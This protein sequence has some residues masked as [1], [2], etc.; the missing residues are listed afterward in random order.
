MQL[1]K[2]LLDSL[3]SVKG[4][5]K[6]AFEK[7]HSSGE[8]VTSIRINPIKWLMVNGEFDPPTDTK[9]EALSGS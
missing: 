1:P 5:N 7:V 8:Q 9:I 4:F 6:Q 2:P 3:E